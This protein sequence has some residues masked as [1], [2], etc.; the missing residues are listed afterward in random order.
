MPDNWRSLYLPYGSWLR[1]L[2]GRY[3]IPATRYTRD[4]DL[5]GER[6][7]LVLTADFTLGTSMV[8][9]PPRAPA[10]LRI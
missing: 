10:L 6:I 5:S 3:S 9:D 7:E 1:R 8:D 4:P 2:P